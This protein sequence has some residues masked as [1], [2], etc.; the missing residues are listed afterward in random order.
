MN[1]LNIPDPVYYFI[2]VFLVAIFVEM[3]LLAKRGLNNYNYKDTVISLLIGLGA[4][5]L[6]VGLKLVYIS[7]FFFCF[8]FKFF[9]F[10][11]PTDFFDV[12][13]HLEHWYIWVLLLFFDDLSFYISHKMEHEVHIFWAGHM[14]HHSSK[15]FNLASA[16]RQGWFEYIYKYI[17][18]VWLP[19]LGFHPLM[20]FC[21]IQINLIYQFFLHTELVNKLGFLEWIMNTPSHHRVHHS[22]EFKYVDKNYGGI[23]IIWDRL[24]GTFK[25]EE[26]KPTYGLTEELPKEN[27]LK[28][29][30]HELLTLKNDMKQTDSIKG[31]IK[32][33]LYAPGWKHNGE[34]KRNKV[35]RV[36]LKQLSKE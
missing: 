9:D 19:F 18:W 16:L 31:K 8:K 12:K 30:T 10:L 15:V 35:L 14:N 25:K 26:T 4:T 21:M 22:S 23:F 6:N 17:F 2:P 3:F 1:P 13:W 36:K 28:I 33:A 5:V 27:V 7:L 29:V 24:F 34:D 32:Y 20:I 11:A